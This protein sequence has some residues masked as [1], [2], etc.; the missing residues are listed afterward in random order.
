MTGKKN[1]TV[2]DRARGIMAERRVSQMALADALDCSRM[3]INRRLLGQAEFTAKDLILMAA[4][5]DVPVAAFFEGV[6]VPEEWTKR[7]L[8]A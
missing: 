6:S 4:L 1:I 2:A 7:S 3:S 8:V 5:C